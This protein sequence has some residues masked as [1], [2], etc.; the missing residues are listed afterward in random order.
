[1]INICNKV[2]IS[3][4]D[5]KPIWMSKKKGF[6]VR[7][8]YKN[9]RASLEKAPYSMIWKAKTPKRIN[10]FVVVD[11]R[12]YQKPTFKKEIGKETLAIAGV[13]S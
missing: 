13:G 11:K 12:H 5:D 8:M 9:C 2:C 7:S 1:M 6:T 3:E 4:S 10:F